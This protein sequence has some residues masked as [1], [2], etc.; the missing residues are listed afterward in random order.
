M[1]GF[2]WRRETLG[3]QGGRTWFGMLEARGEGGQEA[4]EGEAL[5]TQ[6]VR[7]ARPNAS[8]R[9]RERGGSG[10]PGAASR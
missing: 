5:G 1:T 2:D 9:G 7:V 10:P 3:Q 4:R 8:M 6:E